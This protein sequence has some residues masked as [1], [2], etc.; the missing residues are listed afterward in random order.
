MLKYWRSNKNL[1][2]IASCVYTAGLI[3]GAI[4]PLNE[5]KPVTARP[6][7]SFLSL[8]IN[9]ISVVSLIVII[10]VI[11]L[12]LYSIALLLINGYF[13]GSTVADLGIRNLPLLLFYVFPHGIFEITGLILSGALALRAVGLVIS[14]FLG[15]R[16]E[17]S[18]TIVLTKTAFMIV[19]LTIIASIIETTIAHTLV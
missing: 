12:G 17:R 3:L 5:G 18:E 10:G 19:F 9:N 8:L 11:S 1:V 14:I 4:Y 2:Q 6:K 13:L 7:W 16:I 15:Y